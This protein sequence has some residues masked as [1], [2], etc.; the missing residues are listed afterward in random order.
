MEILKNLFV[1]KQTKK[2]SYSYFSCDEISL[3]NWT[4]YLETQDLKYFNSELEETKD[5]KDAMYSVFGEYLELTENRQIISRF[6]KMHKIMKLQSKYDTVSLLLKAL[7]NWKKEMGIEQFKEII[8]QL[9]KWN[10]K[11]DTKKDIFKQIEQIHK[12]IQGLKTQM[13]LL[14]VDFKKDDEKEKINIESEIITVS[15][16]LELK[17]RID[18]KETTL[19]EW[20]EYCKQ[21]KKVSDNGK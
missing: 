10:Y 2:T 8:E 16:I 11:I 4:K 15:R 19:K 14:E 9:D 20:V 1:K 21:A 12:R 17:Y 5:N 6:S 3:Y 18:K 13:Q 7:Y